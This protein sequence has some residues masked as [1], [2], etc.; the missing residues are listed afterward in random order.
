MNDNISNQSKSLEF[1]HILDSVITQYRANI[2]NLSLKYI[3]VSA[4]QWIGLIICTVGVA[5][6]AFLNPTIR[7]S[8]VNFTG[9]D[10]EYQNGVYNGTNEI[11]HVVVKSLPTLA[12]V[13]LS[14]VVVLVI[15]SSIF[16]SFLQRSTNQLARENKVVPIVDLFRF[17]QGYYLNYALASVL[18]G[19]SVFAG[20]I[21]FILPG[22]YL[23]VRMQFV[24]NL[25]VDGKHSALEAISESFR[26]T[27]G[28]RFWSILL[29]NIIFVGLYIGFSLILGIVL[30]IIESVTNTNASTP[31]NI[32][33]G[34]FIAPLFL[35]I[36][37]HVYVRLQNLVGAVQVG[38]AE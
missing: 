3:L 38:E 23:A 19:L 28:D 16:Y 14:L 10:S 6:I 18:V 2:G 26:L 8:L 15:L 31:I 5:G 34:I 27:A 25:I 37:S 1:S 13:L 33:I 29:I 11:F 12:I 4:I 24:F 21:L 36:N 30:T 9:L 17:N 7:D 20:I 32:L 35:L 22:I